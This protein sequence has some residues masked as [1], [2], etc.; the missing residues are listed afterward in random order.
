MHTNYKVHSPVRPN[1]GSARRSRRDARGLGRCHRPHYLHDQRTQSSSFK[2]HSK[3]GFAQKAIHFIGKHVGSLPDLQFKNKKHMIEALCTN[4][5]EA[6]SSGFR[7]SHEAIRTARHLTCVNAREH[8]YI[9]NHSP[10]HPPME[11]ASWQNT[12]GNN[13]ETPIGTSCTHVS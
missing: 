12:V 11:P 1:K 2:S 3:T 13:S 10:L 7:W 5:T 6:D 4:A 8:G 9:R